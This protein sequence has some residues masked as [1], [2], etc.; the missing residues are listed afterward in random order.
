M[1]ASLFSVNMH[2]DIGK[3][4]VFCSQEILCQLSLLLVNNLLQFFFIYLLLLNLITMLNH[5]CWFHINWAFFV[6]IVMIVVANGEWISR[7]S[8]Q[9]TYQRSTSSVTRYFAHFQLPVIRILC[10]NKKSS[11]MLYFTCI[12]VM[13]EFHAKHKHFQFPVTKRGK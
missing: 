1:C 11:N 13:T 8:K 5:C 6:V 10:V 7:V 9:I 12:V 3:A 2:I 4:G